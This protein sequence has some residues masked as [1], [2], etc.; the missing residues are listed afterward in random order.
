[1]RGFIEIPN[2]QDVGL[3]GA[4]E[5]EDI[6]WLVLDKQDGK[7]LLISRCILEAV[8]YNEEN[9]S[10]TWE[11]CTLRSW[12]NND[13]INK[14]FTSTERSKIQST[15][16]SNPD[17]SKYGTEGG[18]DTTD[19]IFLLSIDE[20]NKYFGP[21]CKNIIISLSKRAW[22]TEYA[23]KTRLLVNDENGSSSWWLRSPG[24]SADCAAYISYG[25]GKDGECSVDCT[26]YGVRPA[27]WID[28]NS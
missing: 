2:V 28:L 26:Y 19:K 21:E 18:N 16:L 4:Y 14:A 27:L 23:E 22:G 13:F 10:V 8:P 1:M 6:E 25:G 5:D 20:V 9:K 24:S 11:T 3:F 15:T 12:L 7:A 17:N